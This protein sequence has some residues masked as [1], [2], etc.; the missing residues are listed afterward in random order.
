MHASRSD[1]TVGRQTTSCWSTYRSG[2]TTKSSGSVTP[3]EWSGQLP[4]GTPGT[5]ARARCERRSLTIFRVGMGRAE[6]HVKGWVQRTY[7]KR[8]GWW[9]QLVLDEFGFLADHGYSLHGGELVGIHF[10]Q[11][12]HYIWFV[13]PRRDVVVDYDPDD[14]GRVTI[15]A[16]LIE[17]DD[18]PTV[19]TLDAVLSH[20]LP[21]ALPPPRALL[22]RES[23]ETNVRW[24]AAALRRVASEVL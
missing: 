24:W 23:V 3:V 10:H 8:D 16:Q 4:F 6:D 9:A 7:L 14:P 13:G 5:A 2:V 11:R 12:G 19:T 22:D 20:H 18:P 17:H 1:H 15:G 21:G